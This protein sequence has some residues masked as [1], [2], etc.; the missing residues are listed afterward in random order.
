[1]SQE[2]EEIHLV[3]WDT[4]ELAIL[5]QASQQLSMDMKKKLG[6]MVPVMVYLQDPLI[7]EE[8]RRSRNARIST[9][10][11]WGLLNTIYV[12]NEPDLSPGPTSSRIAVID[13]DAD[14]GQVEEPVEWDARRLHFYFRRK[15][16]KIP[17]TEEH[18]DLPQFH[19]VNVWAIV[20]KILSLFEDSMILGRCTPWGFDGNRLLLYPHAGELSN[21]FYDRSSR[22]IRFYYFQKNGKRVYTCLSHD[23]IAHETG[24]AVLDGLRPLYMEDSSIQTSAFHEFLADLTAVQTAFLNNELRFQAAQESEGDLSRDQIISGIAEEFGY[25]SYKR[26]YLRTAQNEKRMS[27]VKDSLSHYEWSQVLT[28]AMFDILTEMVAM[29]MM[30]LKKNLQKPSMKEAFLFACNRFRRVAFQPL[31]FLPP[32]DVQFSDYARAVLRADAVVEPGDGDGYREMMAGVFRKRG[33]DCSEPY[34]PETLHFYAYDVNQIARSR[35]DAYH[36]LNCNRRQ[37]C[38]PADQDFT[39]LDLYQTDKSAPGLGRLPREIVIQYAWSEPVKLVGSQFGRYQGETISLRC[40]GT[41]I[42]DSRGNLISWQHKPGTGQQENGRR[43]RRYCEDE[44]DRGNERKDQ[45]LAYLSNRIAEGKMELQEEDERK[46]ASPSDAVAAVR[47][48]GGELHFQ[49]KA[50]THPEQ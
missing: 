18:R 33:I 7:A 43:M 25:Y 10:K 26:A 21:A 45:L 39:V 13:F 27:E 44:R 5:Y 38:I 3:D 17:L 14:T 24:H 12:P 36:F 19:Q 30:K 40:G 11:E 42:F 37:L 31:D 41:L 48:A 16:E 6:L 47:G 49:R 22:S 46:K 32:A 35:T 50:F 34:P 2:Q 23:I 28:G 29:R 20:Q 4:D 8:A 15:Q 9:R 1:M